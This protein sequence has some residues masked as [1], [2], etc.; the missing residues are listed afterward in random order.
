MKFIFNVKQEDVKRIFEI[1]VDVNIRQGEEELPA[2]KDVAKKPESVLK[3]K[4]TIK[5]VTSNKT[6]STNDNVKNSYYINDFS[7]YLKA[8]EEYYNSLGKRQLTESEI[9]QFISDNHLERWRITIDDV[10]SDL[11]DIYEKDTVIKSGVK[12]EAG[13]D[14]TRDNYSK[15]ANQTNLS[16]KE[17]YIPVQNGSPETIF[18]NCVSMTAG[19]VDRNRLISIK[20]HINMAL[21]Q[22]NK[23]SEKEK[24]KNYDRL[25]D[26]YYKAA[27]CAY[28]EKK[29]DEYEEYLKKAAKV[30]DTVLNDEAK[31]YRFLR[32]IKS[33]NELSNFYKRLSEI[34]LTIDLQKSELYK[35]KARQYYSPY[36]FHIPIDDSFSIVGRGSVVEGRID[37]G[38]V[39]TGDKVTI[40]YS[41]GT[42]N[43]AVVKGIEMFSHLLDYAEYGDRVGVLLSNIARNDLVG[44][45]SLYIKYEYTY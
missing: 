17:K 28:V 34:Y 13:I 9:Q 26:I 45:V 32:R 44:A 23:F 12:Q 24:E 29:Y 18:W 33:H 27:M 30:A 40:E 35:S 39:S 42:T 43:T 38:S 31:S 5:P 4:D 25:F 11:K 22:Y 15:N 21:L 36:S 41:D 19:P 20:G 6:V 8:L 2:K 7:K 3:Q 10:K 37:C 1:N 16:Q 14:A